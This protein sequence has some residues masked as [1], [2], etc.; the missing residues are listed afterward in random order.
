MVAGAYDLEKGIEVDF[1]DA[2]KKKDV[3]ELDKMNAKSPEELEAEMMMK[4]DRKSV[5]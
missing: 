4:R 2:L 1:K 5:V 3:L